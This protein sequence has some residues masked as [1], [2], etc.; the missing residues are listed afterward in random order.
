MGYAST[1]NAP[2]TPQCKQG[3]KTPALLSAAPMA[4]AGTVTTRVRAWTRNLACSLVHAPPRCDKEV[5]SS[6]LEMF[7]AL[8]QQIRPSSLSWLPR[9]PSSQK[10]DLS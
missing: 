4:W 1:T 9:T 3:G 5:H 8:M 6:C 7:L 10:I 2:G